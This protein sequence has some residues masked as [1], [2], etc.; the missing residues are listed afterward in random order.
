M[1]VNKRCAICRAIFTDD[2]R[3]RSAMYCP[4]CRGDLTR[5][6]NNLRQR[7]WRFKASGGSTVA[8]GAVK[9]I[10][11]CGRDYLTVPLDGSEVDCPHKVIIPI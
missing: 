8:P 5:K 10:C 3:S 11:N 6:R 4:A 2:S 9:M 1:A 7:R